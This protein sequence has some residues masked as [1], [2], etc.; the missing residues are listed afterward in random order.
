MSISGAL[1]AAARGLAASS[2][3]ARADAEILLAHQLG[4]SRAQLHA[5]GGDPL[6]AAEAKA[7]EGDLE[8]R[9]RG[10]PVAYITGE[11]GFWTLTLA[12]GP[13]VLVPRPET[14]LLVEW[15]L[16][17]LAAQQPAQVADLGTGS[18]CIA[19]ALAAERPRAAITAIDLSAAALDRARANAAQLGFPHLRFQQAGFAE[20]LASNPRRFDLLV[21]NPPYVAA[22]DPHLQALRHEP[23]QALTDGADGLQCLR[24]II[25]AAPMALAPGGW[26]LLEHG[27]DQ[28][29]AVRELLR[30]AGFVSVDTRRDLAGHE[31]A[32]AGALR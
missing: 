23:L 2:D 26:L 5:R 4:L 9:R 21:S 16:Q 14:E 11:K 10:E 13:E 20:F 32:T 6:G 1:A 19:L 28:G 3:S 25:A 30:A 31:R 15:A 7:F 8:R 24:E 22:G 29:G 27:H 17:L 18:G 12:V